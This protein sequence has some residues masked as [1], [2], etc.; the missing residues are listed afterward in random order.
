MRGIN[1]SNEKKRDAVV[2]FAAKAKQSHITM[3]LSTG[4]EKQNIKFV[5]TVT[6]IDALVKQHGDLLGVGK[7]IMEKDDEIDME[8]AGKILGKTSKLYKT[9]KGEIAYRVNLVQVLHNPDGSEKE[10]KDVAKSEATISGEVPL[11]WTGRK[12]KRDDAIRKFA[13]TKN[14][15]IFHTNGLSY[16]FLYEMA[17]Q[18]QEEDSMVFIG[19][20]KKGNEPIILN[21]GGEPYRGFL[22]G[23]V[24]GVKYKLVLH[25][26][27]TE[28]KPL[29]LEGEKK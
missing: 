14:Y 25:L 21:A 24:E 26:T 12:F 8:I 18:L 9:A 29:N 19:A 20:G 28:L 6:G 27:N 4:E 3:V 17:K 5:K 16:D 7:A 13:F 11:Q 1:L 22:E 15:Q 2:G 23:R 10:R